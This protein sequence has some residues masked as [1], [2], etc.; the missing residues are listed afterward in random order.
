[1]R[2]ARGPLLAALLGLCTVLVGCTR[3]RPLL[4]LDDIW[5]SYYVRNT[6]YLYLPKAERDPGLKDCLARQ[7][8]ALN[9]FNQ[10]LR[11]QL[12]TQPACTQVELANP[13]PVPAPP[14]GKRF[15]RVLISLDDL[16]GHR[17]KWDLMAPEEAGMRHGAGD[18]AAIAHEVCTLASG[19]DDR[20]TI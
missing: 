3:S 9:A 2:R 8:A 13:L 20:D 10:A 11:L 7:I 6:C 12:R 17:E 1:M 5:N 4:Y 14:A 19:H 15:W 18:A 16:S